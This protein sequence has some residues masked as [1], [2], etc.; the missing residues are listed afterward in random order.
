MTNLPPDINGSASGS[1]LRLANISEKFA[2][3][4]EMTETLFSAAWGKMIHV[5]KPEAK[6]LVTL[7]L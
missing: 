2:N 7:S 5:K 4:F 3:K 1:A 6:N